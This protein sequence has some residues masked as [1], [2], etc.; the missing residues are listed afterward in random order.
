MI[1]SL[2]QR[3][4]KFKPRI[5]LTCF[6]TYQKWKKVRKRH[7]KEYIFYFFPDVLRWNTLPS[8]VSASQA[9]CFSSRNFW[10]IF[11][12]KRLDIR[13]LDIKSVTRFKLSIVSKMVLRCMKHKKQ[14]KTGIWD[15][16][17]PLL[18]AIHVIQNRHAGGQSR[19]GTWQIKWRT[20]F[21]NGT[22]LYLSACSTATLLS[23]MVVLYHVNG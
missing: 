1:M 21:L 9:K 4:I 5:K 16:I 12:N 15:W 6:I 19:T 22:F 18:L 13:L 10:K 7:F 20:K 8:F 23:S 3:K 17:D 11:E 2:K 14:A